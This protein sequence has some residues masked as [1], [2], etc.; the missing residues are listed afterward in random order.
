MVACPACGALVPLDD[1]PVH[2]TTC[3]GGR[4]S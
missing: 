2:V 1:F 4:R 3:Q